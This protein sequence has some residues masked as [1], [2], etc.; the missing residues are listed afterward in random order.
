MKIEDQ[1]KEEKSTLQKVKNNYALLEQSLGKQT[2]D[3]L[4]KQAEKHI[5]FLEETAKY[6]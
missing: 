3:N 1:I 2:Y 5:Q 4:I 6:F